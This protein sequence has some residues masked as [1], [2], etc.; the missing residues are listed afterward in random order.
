M[1]IVL[2]GQQNKPGN[3]RCGRCCVVI[4]FIV[5]AVPSEGESLA[6]ASPLLADAKIGRIEI[7][8]NNIF[9][10]DNPEENNALYRFANTVHFKTRPNVIQNQLLFQSGEPYRVQKLEE[11]ERML[12]KNRYI[13]DAEVVPVRL[14][15]GVVDLEVRTR[16]D[17]TLK[18]SLSF[19]RSGGANSSGIGL[20]E[21]NLFG[22]GS[23][24]GI[25]FKS[26]VDRDTTA[27]RY[28]DKNLFGT[29]YGISAAYSNNSDGFGRHLAIAKPFYSLSSRRA[30]G[31][32]LSSG[33]RIE[34][35][36]DLGNPVAEYD[37]SFRRHE[38]F[39]GWSAGLKDHW[40]RRWVAGVAYEEDD[41]RPTINGLSPINAMPES[42]KFAYPFVGIELLE[43]DYVKARNIDQIGR[44][45]DRHLGAILSVKIGYS[46]AQF[47]SSVDA[48]HLDANFGSSIRPSEKS[49]L[50]YDGSI[51]GRYEQGT[52]RNLL[53][54]IGT[55]YDLRQ[56]DKRLFH[57]R[58][59][60][61]VGKNLDIE[62]PIYIG[63]DNGL[64][65][66]PLRYQTGDKSVLLTLE[67]RLFTDWYP[68]RLFRVGGAI[69][70]DAGRTW[71]STLTGA[72]NLGWL[73][74]VGVGLRISNSR[75][76]VGR[77]LH[78][79]LAFPLDGPS[80]IRHVQL[81]IEAKR[82]F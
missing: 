3:E 21:Y 82:S 50:L 75:S 38:A 47:G 16:D 27:L 13:G 74:D 78:I 60:G 57:A 79:D 9:D 44:I 20:E 19:G 51:A 77:M 61:K 63:G 71:G 52:P 69:F 62:N 65:G 17:W 10:L 80:D 70:F 26:D 64:R 34:T 32:S 40:T 35:L 14:E 31:F 68:F 4:L 45:E 30:R 22:R 48:L 7:V 18:P 2:S 6:P 72:E 56:S 43:D 36:Y 37:H 15:N 8:N 1:A 11:T 53:L 67:Q 81:Q 66:Y 46:S 42:R 25:E 58:V 76:S 41:Y 24:L 49:T 54:S 5:A 33:R 28:A 29:R 73:R 55:R 39:A 23:H 12:R 59:T